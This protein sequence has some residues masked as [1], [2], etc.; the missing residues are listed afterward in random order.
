MKQFV[1]TT[2]F[3]AV[4]VTAGFAFTAPQAEA[5][6]EITCEGSGSNCIIRVGEPFDGD[7]KIT[8]IKEV[9]GIA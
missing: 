9:Q 6:I 8:S 3:A 2:M 7:Y 1:K 5:D 4:L